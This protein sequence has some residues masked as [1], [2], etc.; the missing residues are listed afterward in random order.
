MSL[1]KRLTDILGANVNELI[2]RYEDPELLLKQ[3]VREMEE[4]IRA[5]LGNAAKV[6]AHEKILARHLSEEEA[7]IAAARTIAQE[8]AQR[9]DD[10]QARSALRQKREREVVAKSLAKQLAEVTE[11]AQS[12]RRQI[13]SMR[14]RVDEANRKLVLLAARQR[15][16]EARQRLLRE[17]SDV[18]LGDD[19]FNK[20]DRMCRKV[21]T[22]E[23]EADALADLTRCST[24][25]SVIESSNGSSD[26]EAIE[27]ELKDLKETCTM[28]P[29]SP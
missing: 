4:A 22:M 16:A 29:L 15:A 13:D 6:V 24:R 20:F 1:L 11:A 26:D 5:A 28:G 3:A 17:F 25:C 23:A 14:R 9:G 18:S 21:E 8:A 12:L 2:E 7:A 10:A 19:A 27:N